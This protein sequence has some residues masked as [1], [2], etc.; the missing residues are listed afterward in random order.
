METLYL[1]G[2]AMG[3]GLVSGLNLYATVLAVGLGV[4]L[5]LIQLSPSLAGLGVLGDPL[6][7]LVAGAL[8]VLEFFADKIPWVDSA[9]DSVHTFIR[10]LGAAWIGAA[11]LGHVDPAL[12]VAGFLLA[13]GM[14][15]STHATK[16]GLRGLVNASPEPFSNA[17]LSL[18]E[19]VLAVAGSWLALTYPLLTGSLAAVFAAAFLLLAPRLF[20]VLRAQLL[21][22]AALVRT[23]LGGGRAAEDVF[24]EL[25]PAC[26]R[27]L[28]PG[29]GGPGDFVLRCVTGRRLGVP[30]GHVGYLCLAGD[31]LL[32]LLR[33]WFRMRQ[34]VVDLSRVT[35]TRVHR[36]VLF[37][38]LSLRSGASTG[39]FYFF[40]DRRRPLGEAAGR[41]DAARRRRAIGSAR[42]GAVGRAPVSC[43]STLL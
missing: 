32:V 24:D 6:V 9:W 30:A 38:R 2:T 33:P 14:A 34:Q 22:L 42:P 16:A 41:I 18:A 5:G 43:A 11:A 20:R 36:G 40:R 15:L 8:Y 10:P 7:I 29:I 39:T 1:L 17:G 3:L 23:A 26:A 31:S 13:G 21:A 28:G 27:R 19:D 35:E 25:P 4:N 37:D 12:E